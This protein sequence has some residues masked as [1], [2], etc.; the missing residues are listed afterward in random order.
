MS[1][2]WY[3]FYPGD[4][5]RDTAHLSLTEDGAYRRLLDHY[6][7]TR[8]PIPTYV[9][10]VFR[11]CR[12]FVPAEQE[13]VRSVL[14]Q[15]F[16]E[17]SDGWHNC[18]VDRELDKARDI[19]EKRSQAGKESGRR[20]RS[21]IPT[22]V[23]QV[24]TQPQ[25]QPQPQIPSPPSP[26]DFCFSSENRNLTTSSTR[27]RAGDYSDQDYLERDLRKLRDAEKE[28]EVVVKAQPHLTSDETFELICE[29]AG[30]SVQRGLEIK[31]LQRKWPEA[32][33]A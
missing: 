1:N 21:A 13:A 25:P 23:E 26:P 30:F 33:S 10:Q 22:H 11:I 4:Y 18:R 17:G 31:T 12:A 16:T 29:R 2:A 32:V 20:R 24:F 27:A 6:Y 8:R 7:S 28:V 15:F 14:R 9:E 19:I 5:G 3:A